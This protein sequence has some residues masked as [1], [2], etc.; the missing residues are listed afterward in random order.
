[1]IEVGQIWQA[2]SV[3]TNKDGDD[4][5][6]MF[7]IVGKYK[8]KGQVFFVGARIFDESEDMSEYKYNKMIELSIFDVEGKSYCMG[9]SRDDVEFELEEMGE[10]LLSESEL[11]AI[12]RSN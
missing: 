10:I 2:S 9:V 8:R 3:Y 6:Y 11:R 1:M 4:L 5:F 12:G 7:E